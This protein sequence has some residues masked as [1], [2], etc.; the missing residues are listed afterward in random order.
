MDGVIIESTDLHT[1]AWEI[2]LARHGINPD[3]VMGKMLGK[4]N[5]QIV[6][7]LWGDGLDEAEAARHGADKEQLYREMMEPVF[8]EHVVGGVREFLAAARRV[9]V[10]C[11]LGTN[12]EP[13]NVDF[14][15]ERTGLRQHLLAIVDGHQVE[16]PKPDPEVFL[17]VAARLRVPACNCVVFEDSPGGMTA[18]RAAGAHVVGLLTTLSEAPLADLAIRDFR[19]PRLLPWLSRLTPR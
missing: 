6:R 13:K 16:R 11:A 18:A 15:L 2:Y 17:K 5:D 7:I 3:G 9:G 8:E 14:V 4:R 19:D 1:R 12:A 10:P